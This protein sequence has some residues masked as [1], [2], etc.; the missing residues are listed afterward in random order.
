[1]AEPDQNENDHL[2]PSADLEHW[3]KDQVREWALSLEGADDKAANTL[4]EQDITGRSL[5]LL[6][7]AD[8]R[9]IGVKL[10]P[11]KVLIHARDEMKKLKKE[12][13]DICSGRPCKPYPFYRCHDTYRYVEGN[14]LDVT[15]SGASDFIEPCHEYKAFTNTTEE[16]KM[17]K[18][19]SEVIRFAAACMNS[20]TN[21][22]IHFGI[23]DVPE[24]THGQVLGV[25]VEKD[26]EEYDRKLRCAIRQCFEV[27]NEKTA[28]TCIKPPRFVSVLNTKNT[29]SVKFVIEVDIVPDSSLC[30]DN[31]YHTFNCNTKKNKSK[32]KEASEGEQKQFFVREGGS[33]RNL[34]APTT[35]A[36]PMQDYNKFVTS[37]PQ[38]LQLRR[39]AEE[40]HLSVIKSHNHGSKLCQMITGGT[41]SLDKSCYEH[42]IIVTNKSHPIHLDSIGF[43]V[44]LNPIAVLDFDPQSFK[45]GLCEGFEN[46]SPV[47]LHS[48]DKYKITESVEDI[49]KK[50]QLTRSTSWVFCNGK[51]GEEQPAEMNLWLM[52][53][54]AS[55][56]NVIS[57]LCRKDV[58][59]NK[60]FL[61]VFLLLSR[62]NDKMDPLV[63]T[64]CTFYQELKGKEQILCICENENAFTLWKNLIDTRCEVDISNR[65]IYELS[66]AEVNGTILSLQSENRRKS[67]FLPGAGGGRVLLE[68]K[69]ERQLTTLDVVCVNQCEGG[70]EDQVS[71]EQNFYRGGDVSWWNFYFSEQPGSMPFIKRDKFVYIVD[72]LIPDLCSLRKACV[73]LNL[74]HVPGCGGTTLAKH[75][76]W[77]LREKFRSAV[78]I[79]NDADPVTV[80]EHVVTLLQCGCKEQEPPVP[81]LLMIDD[82][83]DMEKVFNLQQLIEKQCLS[84]SVQSRSPQV[85]LLNCMRSEHIS[86]P[87]DPTEDTVFIGNKLTDDEQKQFD[88]KFVEMEKRHSKKDTKTFYGFM[89]MKTNFD[90]KYI[91]SVVQHTLQKFDMEQKH[92]QLIAVLALISVYCKHAALSL[93]L[94]EEYL[95]LQPKPCLGDNEV[96]EGF[97]QF[98]TL[99]LS[100]NIRSKVLFKGVRMIHSQIALH[101]LKEINVTHKVSKAEIANFI[102]TT[103]KLY[104]CTQGKNRLMQ[105]VHD[106]L[107]KRY[108]FEQEAQPSVLTSPSH[109]KPISCTEQD[110]SCPGN[111]EDKKIESRFSPLIQDIERE[112]PGLEESVLIHA[113]SRFQKDAIISQLLARYYYLKRKDFIEAKKWANTSKKMS[114][115]SSYISDTT[116]QV[117]KHELKYAIAR[118]NFTNDPKVLHRLLKL[119]KSAV[120]A[121]KETQQLAKHES[122][123][124]L[125][126]KR[127]YNPLNTSGFLGEIQ[128]CV[129]IIEMLE[130]IPLFST[131][132][133]RHDLLSSMLSGSTKLDR[134]KSFDPEYK[135]HLQFY[136]VLEEFSDTLHNLKDVMKYNFNFLDKFNVNLGSKFGMKES[137]D[138]RVKSELSRCF[139]KFAQLFCLTESEDLFN[140]SMSTK[141]NLHKARQ[142]IEKEKV[143]TYSG[144]LNCLSND[145]KQEILGKIVDAYKF[146]Y[147][148]VNCSPVEK[149]NYIYMNVVLSCIDQK[150]IE[151][152][153][154]LVKILC[155][156]LKDPLL[157]SDLP[158]YFIAVLLLWP[159]QQRH[160]I[161]AESAELRSYITHLKTAFHTEMKQIY[162]GKTAIVHFF[163]GKK[164]GYERIVHLGEVKRCSKAEKE[165]FATKW[166]NGVIWKNP[167]VQELLCRVTGQVKYKH[168]LV[169]TGNPE[170]NVE[171]TPQFQSQLRRYREGS[172][173]SFFIGFSM[174]GPLAID[175]DQN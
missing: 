127:D 2:D 60:R 20:R 36:K 159:A 161:L 133:V 3:T 11:A 107:V 152:F 57:F 105:D 68:K 72:T 162:N 39:Q 27:R 32:A 13:T 142:F 44:E 71:I 94:C 113:S 55:V 130:K 82:F 174:K 38:L 40:N 33:S 110:A 61:V 171:V 75:T 28:Q 7:T 172:T 121:F 54:G 95:S 70:N 10:G 73:L 8:L 167:K 158:L 106:I 165:Q 81:V 1:M 108:P 23:G 80:A 123:Q 78:L 90:I 117:M 146:I 109:Y 50:L 119:A 168:I 6:T 29:T 87:T 43:L 155:K 169:H 41:G 76:L 4:F 120:G 52:D 14:I 149:M 164:A 135:K 126:S 153:P 53:K 132:K 85:I 139:E 91:K 51:T 129:H 59:R 148:S 92:A 115:N 47:S 46:K 64:F 84:S 42:Y 138:Q 128:V 98:S 65:C 175:I 86:G 102:L 18:F 137:H 69:V 62:V 147:N 16:T 37:V 9:D 48:P 97:Q 170:Q 100:C 125:Q 30:G 12:Q 56:R 19:I 154:E 118:E 77:T 173:V 17:I 141:L 96:E 151:P 83:E 5:M 31:I 25:V 157:K 24:F 145:N 134:L 104:D 15:E 58:L 122:F 144:I 114:Q 140:K 163:L 111:K 26:R 45:N 160:L 88:Q 150:L 156:C 166:E 124:R 21:G 79:D 49:A 99:I 67:R 89:V 112:T 35:N 101:C 103:D 131:G 66:F 143:D 116:A 74:L 63:E 93:S 34:L 136:K 22:T